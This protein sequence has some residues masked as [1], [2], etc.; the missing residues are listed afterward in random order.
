MY[1]HLLIFTWVGEC[2]YLNWIY[3]VA[4]LHLHICLAAACV[5][6]FLSLTVVSHCYGS[7]WVISLCAHSSLVSTEDDLSYQKACENESVGATI[8]KVFVVSWLI[9]TIWLNLCVSVPSE[10]VC[11]A[12]SGLCSGSCTHTYHR[13]F[14]PF[15]LLSP[16]SNS[17]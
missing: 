12:P 7:C 8:L 16:N 6:D 14:N 1:W 9:R 3:I 15:H 5:C 17:W 10:S 4:H 2:T 13:I 11:T